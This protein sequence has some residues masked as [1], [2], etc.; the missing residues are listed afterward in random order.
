MNFIESILYG[1]I[2]GL[3]EL[4]PVS[5]QGHQMIMSFVFHSSQS[6]LRDLFVHFG[7]LAAVIFGCFPY[8]QRL[9]K[10]QLVSNRRRNRKKNTDQPKTT[11]DIRLIKSAFLPMILAMQLYIIVGR[12]TISSWMIALFFLFN[13][14]VLF[15]QE[16]A[17]HGNKNASK[18]T[19]LESA[20][21]GFSAV[22][23]VLP[24]FSRVGVMY[25][26]AIFRGAGKN[27]ALHWIYI[28]SIPAIVLL[29]L[30]DIA[31]IAR[32]GVGIASFA[33]FA[34]CLAAAIF[35]FGGSY[36]A[37]MLMRW[38]SANTGYTFFAYYSWGA[39]LLSMIFY[40]TA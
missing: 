35:A 26:A 15:I 23:S 38:M 6:G 17:P 16:H 8:L 10:E 4:L 19:A 21:I 5:S 34:G 33:E 11:Y 40:L 2:S 27:H 24:G 20:F 14:I 9:Y 12:F 39:A 32:F 1:L 29:M 37:M 28:L 22:L 25:S 18:M 36:L 30:F 31:S 3:T 13:G 7:C